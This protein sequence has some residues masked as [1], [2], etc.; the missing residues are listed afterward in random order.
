MKRICTICARAG[1]KGVRGK[2]V[3]MLHGLPLIAHSVRQG[4]ASGLFDIVAVSSDSD[5][6][7]KIAGE[8]GAMCLVRRPDELATD[9]AAKLPVIQHCVAEVERQLGARFDICVDLDATSPL[10]SIEDIRNSVAML[11]D[12]GAT[13]VITAMPARRSPYFNMVELD[14]AGVPRLSKAP[15]AQVVRR[16]DA[17]ASFDMNASIYVWRRAALES[18][19]SLFSDGTR[20]YVMPE[21]RSIDIDSEVDFLLVE[22]L[23]GRAGA[24]EI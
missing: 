11:E 8:Y 1:S 15:L 22:Q 16:Q 13:N 9:T 7:L 20:L 10:R 2:N 4:V 12:P 3:R 24:G 17:P 23:M 21:E 5:Q 14:S 18:G 6:I 19:S